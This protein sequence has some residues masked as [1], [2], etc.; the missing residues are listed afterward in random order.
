MQHTEFGGIKT[1]IQSA[2]RK[3]FRGSPG[4]GADIGGVMWRRGRA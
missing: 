4:V 3:V 2:L 1:Q